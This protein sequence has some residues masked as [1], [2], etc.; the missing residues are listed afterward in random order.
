ML[1]NKH[2]TI[3][4][5]LAVVF[6]LGFGF[7]LLLAQDCDK[8]INLMNSYTHS[9]SLWSST[10][11]KLTNYQ[12]LNGETTTPV[13]Y[14][15]W[16]SPL[17][18]RLKHEALDLYQGPTGRAM[19][20]HTTMSIIL[21]NAMQN[22]KD[23]ELQKKWQEMSIKAQIDS[24]K[25]ASNQIRCSTSKGITELHFILKEQING[26]ALPFTSVK[27]FFDANSGEI[28]KGM[29]SYEEGTPWEVYEYQ[30]IEKYTGIVFKGTISDQ[31]M[32]NGR[33]MSNLTGYSVKDLRKN[34]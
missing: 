11:I 6:I 29:Y 25:E 27:I 28:K 15:Y 4:K 18:T 2:G 8:Q 33:L 5:L 24:L 23:M 3:K 17:K 12:E 22:S 16:I 14:E 34:N 20:M 30:K 7:N 32:V 13:Q 10:Y 1:I 26:N 9:M 19:V 31:L 21:Q